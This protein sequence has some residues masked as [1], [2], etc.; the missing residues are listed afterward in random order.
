MFEK[1]VKVNE[2]HEV[3][4]QEVGKQG[5]GIA[6]IKGFVIFVKNSKKG[7]HLKVRIIKVASRFAIAEPAIEPEENAEN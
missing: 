2:V 7:E 5:D 1:P 4:I 6:R 3:D